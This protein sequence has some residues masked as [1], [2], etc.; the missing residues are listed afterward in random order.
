MYKLFTKI[1]FFLTWVVFWQKK[2]YLS[3]V[4]LCGCL[5][6]SSQCQRPWRSLPW[7]WWQ[8]R[9]SASCRNLLDARCSLSFRGPSHRGRAAKSIYIIG[10]LGLT[11]NPSSTWP[12]KIFPKSAAES[13]PSVSRPM[14]SQYLKLI[15]LLLP[16]LALIVYWRNWNQGILVFCC[17]WNMPSLCS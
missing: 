9:R 4:P 8:K 1:Y 3:L 2:L 12:S 11:S 15:G 13:T 14:V 17:T 10:T 6:T 5:W 16:S 7:R